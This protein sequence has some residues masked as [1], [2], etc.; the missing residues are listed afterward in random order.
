M[1]RIR[2]Q[3]NH[4]FE[5]EAVALAVKWLQLCCRWSQCGAMLNPESLNILKGMTSVRE[6]IQ[7]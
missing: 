4:E 2:R 7:E 5:R 1:R 3:H 6:G